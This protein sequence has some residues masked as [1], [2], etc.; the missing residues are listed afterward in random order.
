MKLCYQPSH[1]D[2]AALLPCA[3]L[4]MLATAGCGVVAHGQNAD[5]VR[6]QSQGSYDKAITRF[7]QAVASD[8]NN[9]DGYYNLAASYHQLGK[10]QNNPEQLKLAESYYNQCLDRDPNHRDCYRGLAVLLT[11]QSRQAEA[12]RLIEGWVERNPTMAEPKIELARL[13]VES[14]DREAA[15]QYLLEALAA[16]PDNA[17][18][19]ASLGKIREDL[20]DSAQ[21]LADYQRSLWYDRFQPE[22]QARMAALQQAFSSSPLTAT[23]TTAPLVTPPATTQTVVTPPATTTR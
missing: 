21:A 17:A 18:A 2:R 20:G 3:A 11:E 10:L 19:L 12:F 4:M 22:V 7:Q 1:H 23:P 6:L 5:G 16:D 13:F 14:G 15:K 8:P 9:A